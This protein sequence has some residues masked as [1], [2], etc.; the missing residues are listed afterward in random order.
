MK[1]V[2]TYILLVFTVMS[3]H[4]QTSNDEFSANE[5]EIVDFDGLQS[6]LENQGADLLVVNFWATWCI[7]CVEELPF[8]EQANSEL[9]GPDIKV[10]LVSL[11]FRSAIERQL[12]PFI[13][14]N[15]LES[16]IIVLSD[17]KA[18][19]WINL[20]SEQWSG[21]IP[22][23]WYI[24]KDGTEDFHEGKYPDYQTLKNQ[25]ISFQKS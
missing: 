7:P 22:A 25:I 9:G 12:L 13:D 3:V 10:I 5:V 2:L 15:E 18:N 16:E 21:A 23:T 14:K 19:E 4:G 20:V 6:Y 1:K 11:D 24:K 8:F 17:P